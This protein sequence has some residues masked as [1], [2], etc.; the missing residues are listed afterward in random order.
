MGHAQQDTGCGQWPQ[1][2]VVQ[3]VAARTPSAFPLGVFQLCPLALWALA[4]KPYGARAEAD[5]E[6]LVW[7]DIVKSSME[8]GIPGTYL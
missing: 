6:V 2:G 7:A 1:Q 4:A 8:R 5:I 3:R